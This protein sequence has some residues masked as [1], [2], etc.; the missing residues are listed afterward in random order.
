MCTQDYYFGR[1]ALKWTVFWIDA[2]IRMSTHSPHTTTTTQRQQMQRKRG[3]KLPACQPAC[4]SRQSMHHYAAEKHCHKLS[5]PSADSYPAAPRTACPA[6]METRPLCSIVLAQARVC[7][8]S[9]RASWRGQPTGSAACAD[10]ISGSADVLRKTLGGSHREGCELR[11]E[12]GRGGSGRRGAAPG[13]VTRRDK[14]NASSCA[15]DCCSCAV[16][17]PLRR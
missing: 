1:S 10:S 9:P 14:G 8:R 13:L 16:V 11:G 6:Q 17:S 7:S 5:G 12:G 4:S 15:F 3:D 2:R